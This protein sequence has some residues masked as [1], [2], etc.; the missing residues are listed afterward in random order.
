[1]GELFTEAFAAYNLPLTLFLGLVF[2]YWLLV[3]VGA[4]DLDFLNIDLD[5]D[6]HA[7][8]HIDVSSAIYSY[9]LCISIRHRTPMPDLKILLVFQVNVES[10]ADSVVVNTR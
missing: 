6:F 3:I 4:L 2:L 5:H 8:V 9:Y 10:A 7:D 1:M